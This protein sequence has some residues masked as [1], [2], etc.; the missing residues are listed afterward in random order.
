M[1]QKDD[2]GRWL[3]A[4]GNPVPPKYVPALDKRRDAMVEKIHTAA[5][6]QREAL[7]KF[8]NLAMDLIDDHIEWA[9]E[10]EGVARNDGGNY[11]FTGFSGD[12]QVVIKVAEYLDLD[13]R[14]QI[15]KELVDNCI[16]R[17]SE[18]AD[19][20]LG[21]I[22]RD[23]F[24]VDQKGRINVRRILGLRKLQIDDAEW[25]KAM[26]LIGESITVTSRR[27]YLMIR[28]RNT[29]RGGEWETIKLD[30]ADV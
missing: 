20:R 17:W 14:I 5:L 13:E 28:Q 29:E 27:A 3:D 2:K 8:R 11:Q 9:H 26:R 4:T 1:A 15:A 21:M 30:L 16:R 25:Q 18:G 23:A 12:K 19:D 7:G 6:K 24:Q 22:V 10:S